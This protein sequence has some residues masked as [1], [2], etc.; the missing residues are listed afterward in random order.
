[1][2]QKT[3]PELQAAL[4]ED[5]TQ[6]RR[7]YRHGSLSVSGELMAND[8]EAA[9]EALGRFAELMPIG[10]ALLRTELES[11]GASDEWNRPIH[12]WI[13]KAE[14]ALNGGEG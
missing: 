14:A 4:R 12:D 6:L 10:V 11:S 13:R 5:A 1:M 7:W 8:L 3:I 9:A 2:T